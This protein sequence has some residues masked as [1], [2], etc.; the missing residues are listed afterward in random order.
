MTQ[1]HTPKTVSKNVVRL[2]SKLSTTASPTFVDVMPDHAALANECF[3][4]VQSKIAVDG[5]TMVLGWQIWEWPNVIVEAE[6]HAIWRSPSGALLDIT[7]KESADDR[8][9]F[10]HAPNKQYDGLRV[11]NVRLALRDDAIICH[12]IAVSALIN[13]LMHVGHEKEYGFVQLPAYKIVPLQN[14]KRFLVGALYD[15]RRDHDC[16]FCGAPVKYKRCCGKMIDKL[17]IETT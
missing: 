16:C 15:G 2:L 11:D 4:N 14:A 10:V 13:K 9:L 12:F 6:F 1:T 17:I 5:G 3:A 8:I 7:P